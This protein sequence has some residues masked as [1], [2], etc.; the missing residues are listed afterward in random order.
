M[1]CHHFISSICLRIGFLLSLFQTLL[2]CRRTHLHI[3]EVHD[4]V[5]NI[6]IIS[7]RVLKI[8]QISGLVFYSSTM[9][10]FTLPYPLFILC[11]CS[12]S[13][14][15]VKRIIHGGFYIVWSLEQKLCQ[16]Y[17]PSEFSSS[18]NTS[19]YLVPGTLTETGDSWA[20]VVSSFYFM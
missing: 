8:V 9:I 2:T 3:A 12:S 18:I 20:C 19:L 16:F 10:L 17:W 5:Y 1:W 7:C 11:Y 15:Y 4:T 6:S 13:V 14:F